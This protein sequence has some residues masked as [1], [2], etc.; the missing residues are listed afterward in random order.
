MKQ[1][2]VT[3]SFP[4]YNHTFVNHQV[5]STIA[6]GH[7]VQVLA[8]MTGDLLGE[9]EADRLGISQACRIYLD[10]LKLPMFSLELQRFTPRIVKAAD[11]KTYGIKMSERR[12]TFFSRLIRHQ[13]LKDLDIIHAHFAGWAY[14]VAIPLGKLLNVP[15]T[16][17]IHNVELPKMPADYLRVIQRDAARVILVS[18]E[19]KRIWANKTGATDKLIVVANGV[20]VPPPAQHATSGP[21]SIITV[22]RMVREK[23][24]HE[25][26]SAVAALWRKGIDCRYEIIGTGPEEAALKALATE[27]GIVD[28]VMFHGKMPNDEVMKKLV[29]ADILLHPSE[30]ESFG[31]AVIEGMAASLPVVAARTRPVEAILEQSEAGFL[32]NPGDME[33]LIHRLESL[34]DSQDRRQVFGAKAYDIAKTNYSWQVHMTKMMQIWQDIVSEAVNQA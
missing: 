24:I 28:R 13:S 9:T 21:L 23:R 1:L 7:D 34:A 5:A 8:P 25:G 29:A 32:Y 31:I 22:A 2:V 11:R 17:T 3:G 33:S 15:V 18:E 14:E 26:L 10:Y 20:D 30:A 4:Y 12:K 19:W 6:A 27:L 16:V